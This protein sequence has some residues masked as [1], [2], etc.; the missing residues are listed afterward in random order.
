MEVIEI[1]KEIDAYKLQEL[2]S[3]L[4]NKAGAGVAT[5]ELKCQIEEADQ[6][7]PGEK[8]IQAEEKSKE[9]FKGPH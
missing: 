8:Y 3:D 4:A 9:P 2:L 6:G 5:P 7:L 1:A